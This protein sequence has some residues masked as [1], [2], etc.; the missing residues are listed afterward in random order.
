MGGLKAPGNDGFPVVFFFQKNW[1]IVKDSMFDVVL[2]ISK[3]DF[4][5][6]DINQKLIIL[7]PKIENPEFITQLR[8]ISLCNVIYK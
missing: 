2:K 7:I 1:H 6:V 3:K 5:L 4:N 8:P